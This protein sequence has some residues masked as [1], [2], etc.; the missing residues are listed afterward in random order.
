H[1]NELLA[2][3]G[4]VPPMTFVLTKALSRS[5]RERVLGKRPTP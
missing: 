1:V 4:T 5:M 2:K 3:G